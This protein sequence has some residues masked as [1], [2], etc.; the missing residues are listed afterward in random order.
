MGFEVII[1]NNVDHKEIESKEDLAAK[2]AAERQALVKESITPI[3]KNAFDGQIDTRIRN[4]V[5]ADLLKAGKKLDEARVQ[6]A[7]QAV[8]GHIYSVKSAKIIDTIY[9]IE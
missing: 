2:S 8:K 6:D 1:L 9:S 4:L 5:E 3:D 7:I